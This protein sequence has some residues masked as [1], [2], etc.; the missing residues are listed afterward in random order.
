MAPTII[1][2]K[3]PTFKELVMDREGLLSFS[4]QMAVKT[5]PVIQKA[6]G[7]DPELLFQAME[8]L[9]H[10]LTNVVYRDGAIG[11]CK[12]IKE[13]VPDQG[14]RLL[15][16]PGRP[17]DGGKELSLVDDL[18]CCELTHIYG[19]RNDAAKLKRQEETVGHLERFLS[20]NKNTFG[21]TAEFML[22]ADR[23]AKAKEYFA[24]TWE[25]SRSG[26]PP[27]SLRRTFG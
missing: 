13:M 8:T 25:W 1:E 23:L 21:E 27:M 18:V 2:I 3:S 19:K 20:D 11:V 12:L 7:T 15:A 24:K 10:F 4:C 14:L 26:K 9:P 6:I 16:L 17:I 5:L 22:V